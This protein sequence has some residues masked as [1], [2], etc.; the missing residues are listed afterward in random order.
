[1]SKKKHGWVVE[2]YISPCVL[3]KEQILGWVKWDPKIEIGNIEIRSEADILFRRI[4]NV[5]ERVFDQDLSKGV[6]LIDRR[7]MEIP[8]YVGFE[9]VYNEI[10]SSER[11][12]RFV[13]NFIQPTKEANQI[14]LVTKLIR[15]TIAIEEVSPTEIESTTLNPQPRPLSFVL[16]KI[17][18]A[19]IMNLRPFIK[20]YEGE[21]LKITVDTSEIEVPR[22]ELFVKSTKRIASKIVIR[23]SGYGMISLGFRYQ[24]RIHNDYETQIVE[25]V[26]HI[27]RKQKIEVPVGSHVV[28]GKQA[29]ILEP[30]IS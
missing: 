17:G 6:I 3:P 16:K 20:T 28:N 5:A 24:D 2:Q 12:L 18:Y 9:A 19:D 25:I 13:I 8:G 7:D 23:G 29:L 27:E 22:E 4:I 11:D 15:P 26:V 1:M 21:D 14:E 10:P 30:K